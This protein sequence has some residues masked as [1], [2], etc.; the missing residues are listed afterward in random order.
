[1][2]RYFKRYLAPKERHPNL[3]VS[4][5]QLRSTARRLFDKKEPL[6]VEAHRQVKAGAC[7]DVD[8]AA[9]MPAS[10]ETAATVSAAYLSALYAAAGRAGQSAFYARRAKNA[11]LAFAEIGVPKKRPSIGFLRQMYLTGL[12]F[13]CDLAW[14]TAGWTAAEGGKMKD[15]LYE[16]RDDLLAHMHSVH[17]S[18]HGAWSMCRLVTTAALFR[19]EVLLAECLDGPD[20]F[21]HRVAHEFFDDG[22][23]YEQ[24]TWGYQAY[25]LAPVVL[26]AFAARGAGASPDPF[27]LNV[28]NDLSLTYLGGSTGDVHLPHYPVDEKEFPRPKRKSLAMAL[29]ACFDM[30]RGD[31]T[32]PS[33]GD[34]G[35]RTPPVADHWTTELAW[36]IYGDRRAARLLSMGRRGADGAGY[37]APGLLTLA[38][39]K[40]LPKRA[41]FES[42]S[43]IYPHAGHAVL[44]SIEGDSFWGSDSI[45]VLLKFGPFGNG[46]GHADKLHLDI[47]GAGRK[48]CTEELSREDVHWRYWNSSVSH[49]TVVVG[50][51]S[52]PGNES[53]FAILNDSCGR[54]VFHRFDGA[55]KVACA[56]AG[57]VYDG[58]KTYRR[59]VAVSDCYVLD[60]FEV[61]SRKP[62]VFDWMLHG[63][64][65]L[66][67][68]GASLEAGSLGAH[69]HGYQ[70]LRK[71]RK[72]KTDG[73][74]T[75]RFSPGHTV[76]VPQGAATEVFSARGPWKATATRPVLILRRRGKSAVFVAVHDPSGEAVKGVRLGRGGKGALSAIIELENGRDRVKLV[77]NGGKTT[78]SRRRTPK[79]KD[80]LVYSKEREMF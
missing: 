16:Y 34:Y 37:F 32:C 27:F 80:D 70:F 73:A 76:F 51:R 8:G 9:G 78:K 22:M 1:M 77:G 2:K 50:R 6:L 69:R 46:H 43:T 57:D 18:N 23:N 3:L 28:D 39:G 5:G 48:D 58:L 35:Q 13:A 68:K 71:V 33:I 54:L 53:M 31:T 66:T 38:F 17:M 4:R 30:L 49:N 25:S 64:G 20:S 72:G 47:A 74:I 40:P 55:V 14:A 42:K 56:E 10:G 52:Q 61:E 24:S 41:R 60:V 59:T 75:A 26:S 15:L 11:L 63:K 12:A 79:M 7:P 29:T 19:D 36:D 62:T 44:K 45:H 21:A 67:V 65:R